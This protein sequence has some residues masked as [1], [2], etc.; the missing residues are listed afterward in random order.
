MNPDGTIELLS[1]S[2]FGTGDAGEEFRRQLTDL[3]RHN[4]KARASWEKLTPEE[5]A[6]RTTDFHAQKAAA[7]GLA[8]DP[9][10]LIVQERPQN[11]L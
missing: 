11:G 10:P 9:P 3:E 8:L 2:Y 4:Q 7:S 6:Q 5:Q 1:I